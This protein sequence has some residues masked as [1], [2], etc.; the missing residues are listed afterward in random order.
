MRLVD[1][2]ADGEAYETFSRND[3]SARRRHDPPD[4]N[5][6]SHRWTPIG[7]AE[8]RRWPPDPDR[9]RCCIHA[10]RHQREDP[11]DAH[12]GAVEGTLRSLGEIADF[13]EQRAADDL[14][15]H[16][17]PHRM[18]RAS[19]CQPLGRA[20]T[21]LEKLTNTPT[22][23]R[24]L[25]REPTDLDQCLTKAVAEREAL[26]GMGD[27]GRCPTRPRGSR[28]GAGRASAA[29]GQIAV[30]ALLP[31]AFQYGAVFLVCCACTGC[32]FALWLAPA[33][34]HRGGELLCP[35]QFFGFRA[36]ADADLRALVDLEAV[37]SLEERRHHELLAA[38]VVVV[39][40]RQIRSELLNGP[41][42]RLTSID[43]NGDIRCI[44]ERGARD[45]GF[46]VDERFAVQ[47][48]VNAV[49]IEGTSTAS[50][51]FAPPHSETSRTRAGKRHRQHR[52]VHDHG[53]R[54]LDADGHAP[55]FVSNVAARQA[56]RKPAS[57]RHSTRT[58]ARARR[59]RRSA[60]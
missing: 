34:P 57:R 52:G 55:R 20:S 46:A 31:P 24:R 26:I 49:P 19:P 59:H 14:G 44:A 41:V 30:D 13:A 12:R 47:L 15:T 7:S 42:G 27:S 1:F 21:P 3:R 38:E 11:A 6:R 29:F 32:A 25:P 51:N 5:T 9:R 17:R 33:G 4:L 36:A 37:L 22:P 58:A 35:R 48:D 60:P 8:P 10:T 18:A 2:A 23:G 45:P 40:R 39:L 50:G 43:S 54:S 53:C 56:F 28:R 16:A